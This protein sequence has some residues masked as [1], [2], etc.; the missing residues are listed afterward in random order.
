[1][2]NFFL[3]VNGYVKESY[4]ELRYKVSWP[5]QQELA[6]STVVVMIASLIM[7]VVIFGID[8]VFESIVKIFYSKIF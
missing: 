1:M 3:R 2:K 8:Q 7:A 4:S 6:S 5:T